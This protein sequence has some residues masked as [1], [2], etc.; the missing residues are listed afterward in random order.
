MAR[1]YESLPFGTLTLRDHLAL[2]RNILANER[3]LLAYAR[4]GFAT[5]VAGL[6]FVH[7][8]EGSAFSTM[9][10]AC[11]VLGLGTFALGVYRFRKMRVTRWA[12]T[13]PQRVAE[14]VE[15]SSLFHDA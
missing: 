12:H 10:W 1:R 4:T 3:T 6:S 2:D 8:F 5:I 15:R 7:F 13:Y 14:M 9:G 11:V